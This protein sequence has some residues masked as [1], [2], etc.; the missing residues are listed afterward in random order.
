MDYI[1]WLLLFILMLQLSH[2]LLV[3]VLSSWCPW[4]LSCSRH[5]LNTSLLSGMARGSR[6]ILYF[7][8]LA[9]GSATSPRRP[10]FFALNE[11][12]YLEFMTWVPVCHCCSALSAARG[13]I[14]MCILSLCYISLP[15]C[16]HT[17]NR[18]KCL[19]L[20]SLINRSCFHN[21]LILPDSLWQS[22]LVM[23]A[24]LSQIWNGA[25]LTVHFEVYAAPE[26]G[27]TGWFHVSKGLP[28]GW[29]AMV[30]FYLQR[31]EEN[32]WGISHSSL[33]TCPLAHGRQTGGNTN[34]STNDRRCVKL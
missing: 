3:G 23:K 34:Q 12:W 14:H 9:P 1:P 24:T 21:D 13:S 29:P 7:T 10:G 28:S 33:S 22:V 26:P 2:I 8:A 17:D 19:F 4:F 18:W 31:A 25:G 5:S 16:I 20:H 27:G 32:R 30:T 11:V 15:I 6:L